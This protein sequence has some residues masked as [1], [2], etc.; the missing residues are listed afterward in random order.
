ML[1]KSL[2]ADEFIAWHIGWANT[3][4]QEVQQS[5]AMQSQCKVIAA[6]DSLHGVAT[7]S[8]EH[9]VYALQLFSIW[10]CLSFCLLVLLLCTAF[11]VCHVT[12]VIY[13]IIPAGLG[14]II[15]IVVSL[16]LS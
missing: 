10:C 14:I 16:H 13:T 1:G 5:T 4:V 6:A 12:F 2:T 9:T 11:Y 3:P 7:Y 15:S 8:G